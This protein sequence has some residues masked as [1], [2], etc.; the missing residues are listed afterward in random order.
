MNK[1]IHLICPQSRQQLYLSDDQCFYQ[2]DDASIQ[3]PIEDGVVRF[4]KENDDFYEGAYTATVKWLPKSEKWY[5]VWPLWGISSGYIWEIRKYVPARSILLEIASGG[6]VSYLG[7]R[8]KVIGLDLSLASLKSC[9]D[10][11][12]YRIQADALRI[13][14]PNQSVDAV[15]SSCFW[16]HIPPSLKSA[17]LL[18]FKRVLKSD[19]YLIFLFDIYTNNKTISKI[20]LN[21]PEFYQ[22]KF[23]D[24]DGHL[25]YESVT[26][27]LGLFK[28]YFNQVQIRGIEKSIFMTSSV[29]FKLSQLGIAKYRVINAVFKRLGYIMKIY[30]FIVRMVDDL[31]CQKIDVSRSRMLI[32]IFKK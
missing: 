29:Y 24:I 23:L 30:F 6:G 15:V 7:S 12:I 28:K 8:Y 14:L 1:T 9:P 2:T 5:H 25:G 13:P 11:Y 22:Q 16:E 10:S 3:Y 20:R 18:E 17:F 19:G 32:T 4:L 31:V 21:H 27:N 26:A